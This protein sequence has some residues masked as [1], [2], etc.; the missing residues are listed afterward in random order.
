MS[1]EYG[2]LILFQAKNLVRAQVTYPWTSWSEAEVAMHRL[3]I[4]ENVIAYVICAMQ[5]VGRPWSTWHTT[6]QQECRVL[7]KLWKEVKEVCVIDALCPTKG[8]MVI[9]YKDLYV[10]IFSKKEQY[11]TEKDNSTSI[12]LKNFNLPE[13]VDLLTPHE[14]WYGKLIMDRVPI[15]INENFPEL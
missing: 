7:R 13:R 6:V 1:S 11:F 15:K 3:H 8:W 5:W 14:S 10:G 12:I 4:T 2:G 9:M